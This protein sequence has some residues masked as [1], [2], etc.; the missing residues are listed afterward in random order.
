MWLEPVRKRQD[1]FTEMETSANLFT[2]SKR[3]LL[4]LASKNSCAEVWM[5][6]P[7]HAKHKKF[8]FFVSIRGSID[9][10]PAVGATGRLTTSRCGFLKAHPV[11][12]Q[13]IQHIKNCTWKYHTVNTESFAMIEK[14]W[15]TLFRPKGWRY[16][17]KTRKSSC[18]FPL[19]S[20]KNVCLF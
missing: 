12:K 8:A 10:P 9:V 16:D 15:A 4:H 19:T 17:L 20:K 6:A 3:Q 7:W 13:T 14:T 11:T 2:T 18:N 1:T 5:R